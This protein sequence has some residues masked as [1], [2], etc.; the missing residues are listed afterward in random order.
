VALAVG[1]LALRVDAA[2][3]P[4]EAARLGAELTP[5]G[6]EQAGNAQ[7]TIPA[8]DGGLATPARAGVPTFASPGRAPDPFP[9]DRP[10]YRVTAADIPQF[11][12]RLGA[13][14]KALLRAYGN[15]FYL[16][17]YPTRRSAAAPARVYAATRQGA[18]AASLTAAGSGVQGATGGI[19]FPIPKQ[20]LEIYWNHQLRYRGEAWVREVSEAVVEADGR[21]ALAK[22]RDEAYFVYAHPGGPPV[23]VD[24]AYLYRLRQPSRA[25]ADLTLVAELLAGDKDTRRVL[26]VGADRRVRKAPPG[27][28]DAPVADG[29]ATEDQTDM[30]SGSPERYDWKL[31]GKRELIVPYNAYR[32]HAAKAR[33]ATVLRRGHLEPALLRYELHRV[34]LL[35]ATLKPGQ[36]HPYRRRVLYVDEDS[37][38]ILAVDCYD[39]DDRL[40]RVQE[41]HAIN[42]YN[43]PA[44]FASVEVVHDLRSGRYA[45]FGLEDDPAR[46]YDFGIR[47]SAQDYQPAALAA[48]APR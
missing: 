32:L 10:L 43:L 8:W 21:Y 17:V 6:A 2:I 29:L 5:L 31:L 3:S 36:K 37:W 4:Q 11:D 40:W 23:D 44:F 27:G 48:R 39:A 42:Y 45:V 41:A 35:A 46:S 16:D 18:V 15:S 33:P 26:I 1:L 30:M 9:A 20:A 22:Y 28:F 34:W 14:T 47:R 13:G 25:G 7:G 38:Q 12:T 24:G 19:P